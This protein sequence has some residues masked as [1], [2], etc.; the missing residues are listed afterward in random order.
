MGIVWKRVSL[1]KFPSKQTF[2]WKGHRTV[3]VS[4]NINLS[5]RNR[6]PKFIG[7]Q[8]TSL[9]V[10]TCIGKVLPFCSFFLWNCSIPVIVS[11]I[12]LYFSEVSVKY[13]TLS[14]FLLCLNTNWIF[15]FFSESQ[16]TCPK[17]WHF[18]C[19]IHAFFFCIYIAQGNSIFCMLRQYSWIYWII[20]LTQNCCRHSIHA[21]IHI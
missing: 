17:F 9:T 20:Q 5:L 7:I 8:V 14:M 10:S 2:L 4:V 3:L 1:S 19:S 12:A 13:S 21:S 15:F 6:S 11:E 16:R 18:S